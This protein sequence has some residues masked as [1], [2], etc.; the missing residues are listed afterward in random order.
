MWAEEEFP[1]AL[2]EKVGDRVPKLGY[3]VRVILA[4]E[5][6]MHIEAKVTAT[7]AQ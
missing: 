1:D 3:D 4:D 7:T 6:E 5:S 2:V